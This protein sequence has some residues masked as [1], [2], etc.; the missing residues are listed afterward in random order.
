MKKKRSN[1][2]PVLEVCVDSVESA[3][4]AEKGGA[5]RLELCANLIIGGTSPTPALFMEIRKHVSIPIRVLLR[6]RFGDFCYTDYEYSVLKEEV[7]IF[8]ELG[9]EGIVIGIL[10]PDGDLD[11]E[12][13]KGLCQVAEGMEIALHRAFDVC[14]NPMKTL[15]QTKELGIDTILTGGQQNNCMDGK[16][17]LRDLV[18]SA[19]EDIEILIGSGVNAE[20]IAHLGPYTGA[21]SFHLS[22][23]NECI[24]AMNYRKE[25]VSMGLPMMSEYIIWQTDAENVRR[26]KETLMDIYK[27]T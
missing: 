25:S 24:S 18:K 2:N 3:I 16:K 27:R 21:K 1:T 9:A 10:K 15:E 19:G 6:P 11:M 14:K 8:R 23:K 7:K 22:G 20:A 26:A 5:D 12:R 13:M 4:A 17:L